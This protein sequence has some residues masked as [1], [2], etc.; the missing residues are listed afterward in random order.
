SRKQILIYM[1]NEGDLVMSLTGNVGR[2]AMLNKSDLPAALNQRVTCI[3]VESTN[4]LTRFLFHFFNQDVFERNEMK[5]ST[6]AGQKNLSTRWLKYY[7]I[8]SPSLEVQQEIVD[9]LDK[10]DA[11]VNDLSIGLPA[12][13]NARRKQYEYYRDKLLTFKE[14]A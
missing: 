8:P 12:E 9:I 10:F 14:A 6:G 5:N 2:V 4:I 11:L 7:R 3:R 1:L 13:I